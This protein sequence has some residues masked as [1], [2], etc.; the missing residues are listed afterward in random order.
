MQQSH[1]LLAIAKLLVLKS[2]GSVTA[3]KSFGSEFYTDGPAY[4]KARS[5]NLVHNHGRENSDD[6]KIEDR[7]VDNCI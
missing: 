5:R 4:L 6:D 1:G 3:R 2:P 7:D